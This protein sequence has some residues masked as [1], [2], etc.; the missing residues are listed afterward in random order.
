VKPRPRTPLLALAERYQVALVASG[1]LHKA[2]DF[3]RANARYV[4]GPA[5]SFLVGG[6]QPEMPGA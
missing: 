3:R 4:W 2:H 5:S 6:L 1:H